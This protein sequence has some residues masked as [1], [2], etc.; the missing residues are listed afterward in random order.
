MK[1]LAKVHQKPIQEHLANPLTLLEVRAAI[2]AMKSNKAPGPDGIPAEI[3]KSSEA[4]AEQLLHNLLAHIWEKEDVP[5]QFKDANIVTILKRKGSKSD[6]SNYRGISLLAIAG[7][8][9]GK[10]L[11]KRLTTTIIEPVLPESQCGFRANR[12]TTDIIFWARQAQEKSREQHKN[13]YMVFNCS[14]TSPR[15]LIAITEQACGRSS[16]NLAVHLN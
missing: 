4:L 12:G 16:R 2:Q 1:S 5:Q 11:L 9:L 14:L 8:I 7:K 15:H 6:Y 13:L 3:C 10:V